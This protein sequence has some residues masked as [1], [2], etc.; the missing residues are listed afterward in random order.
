VNNAGTVLLTLAD[1]SVI[2]AEV[3]RQR[4]TFERS[5]GAVG[6]I[7]IHAIPVVVQRA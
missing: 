1:M 4:R 6:E 7:S 2:Q 5:H 3:S